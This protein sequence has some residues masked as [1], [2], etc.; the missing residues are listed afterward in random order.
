LRVKV[1]VGTLRDAVEQARATIDN[2]IPTFAGLYLEASHAT[3]G[4]GRIRVYSQ[5]PCA[6]ML[7]AIPAE[8]EV[9]G[10]VVIR[11][12]QL[13]TG[14]KGHSSSDLVG[15]TLVQS[16]KQGDKKEDGG[17]L[18]GV[19]NNRSRFKCAVLTGASLFADQIAKLPLNGTN[20]SKFNATILADVIKKVAWCANSSEINKSVIDSLGFKRTE[21]GFRVYATDGFIAARVS[22]NTDLYPEEMTIP[23]LPLELLQ[24]I[25]G[26]HSAA[27]I[28]VI[29]GNVAGGEYRELYFKMDEL[30][31][32]ASTSSQVMP[33]IETVFLDENR[34]PTRKVI[35]S[36][37]LLQ[38][39]LGRLVGFADKAAPVIHFSLLDDNLKLS[40][41]SADGDC[42]EELPIAYTGDSKY[43]TGETEVSIGYAFI[44]KFL[45]AI[46]NDLI[47]L[48]FRDEVSPM[49]VSDEGN[50]D[51]NTRYIIMCIRP[52]AEVPPVP[53][54]PV[55]VAVAVAVVSPVVEE[56]ANEEQ[57]DEIPFPTDVGA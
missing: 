3:N 20:G 4:N 39:M 23:R 52:K 26:K 55:A 19:V 47:T 14:L 38:D 8:V 21:H 35:V 22:V 54:A 43:K 51:I 28:S 29:K 11:P 56:K 15:L 16:Q 5:K 45:S 17:R 48:G 24:K 36:R 49:T 46:S 18:S 1:E 34:M 10:R 2:T 53:D 37:N 57:D 30:F 44:H 25:L 27:E 13:L 12:D 31:Y 9:E 50:D 32:G 7:V 6:R 33:N 40:T 41:A 42:E